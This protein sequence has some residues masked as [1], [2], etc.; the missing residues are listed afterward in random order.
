MT[1]TIALDLKYAWLIYIPPMVNW[2]TII[3]ATPVAFSLRY[4][5][6]FALGLPFYIIFPALAWIEGI[7]IKMD[8]KTNV[9]AIIHHKVPKKKRKK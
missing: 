3:V 5:Y 2:L 8:A 6:V 9:K 1:V 7:N 4:V